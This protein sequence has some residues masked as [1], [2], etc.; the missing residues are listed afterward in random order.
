[1]TLSTTTMTHVAL[2]PAKR[3]SSRCAEKNWRTFGCGRNLVEHT[4]SS[5]PQDVF[6]SVILSTDRTDYV[7]SVGC[8]VHHRDASLA[9][10]DADV[11]DLIRVV[12]ERYELHDS[13]VWLLNPTT[14]FRERDDFERIHR[15]ISRTDCPAVVSVTPVGPFVW[16]GD[17][18][19]FRTRGR[20]I[21]TQDATGRYFVE[22]GMFY[23]FRADAFLSHGTWY[24][25]GTRRFVQEGL[26]KTID[27]DTPEQFQEA[28]RV[29]RAMYGGAAVES[30]P[31]VRETMRNETLAVESL[32]A[33]PVADHLVLLANHIGRYG[34]AIDALG[35]DAGA[36]VLDVSCGSGYGSYL[37]ARTA[38]RVVGLDVNPEFL[39]VARWAFAAD[40]L[41]FTTYDRYFEDPHEPVDKLVC[42]ETY[43]H[44][45]RPELPVF[46]ERIFGALAVGGDAFVTCPLGDDGP[47]DVN[48]FHL[49]EPRL[50]TLHQQFFARFSDASYRVARRRDSFGQDGAYCCATLTGYRGDA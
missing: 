10:V 42:I 16:K 2:V 36:S 29:W 14:P 8:R 23:V 40:N 4:L 7:P 18:P 24:P 17:E 9:T 25:P 32:I 6:S 50:A 35:I 5:I 47:S 19:L 26:A 1:M 22:N 28:Q 33:P 15:L 12:I 3:H 31:R 49:N 20:R 45:S 30:M 13:Y 21:N 43:E 37:L 34:R 11:G 41:E 46:L 44:L 39:G 27:I 48:R 38:G